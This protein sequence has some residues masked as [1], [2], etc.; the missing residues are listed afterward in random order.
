VTTRASRSLAE[1]V[2]AL[3]TDHTR[4]L[5]LVAAEGQRTAEQTEA[6]MTD[7]RDTRR[8][9]QDVE[10]RVL[11]V[12]GTQGEM[13]SVLGDMAREMTALRAAVTTSNERGL[14]KDQEL[15]RLVK[16]ARSHASGAHKRVSSQESWAKE[17]EEAD[18]IRAEQERRENAERD[19]KIAE[20]QAQQQRVAAEEKKYEEAAEAGALVA[21]QRAEKVS[22]RAALGGGG[23]AAAVPTIIAALQG[24][25]LTYALG[26]GIGLG[27]V[28]V[29]A[30]YLHRHLRKAKS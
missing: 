8:I 30:F 9:L 18:R 15:E 3:G 23:L 17:R 2:R 21:K 24:Q 1:R 16:D 4:A 10:A 25:A 26:V 7:H 19:R 22:G 27:A 12:A 11:V 6:L 5:A 28:I 29:G 14:K 13:L 20:L